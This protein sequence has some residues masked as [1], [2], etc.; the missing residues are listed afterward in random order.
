VAEGSEPVVVEVSVGAPLEVVW[1][2]LRDPEL[3]KRW[4]GW[5]YDDLDAEVDAIYVDDV[6]VDEGA[7][8]LRLGDGDRFE[9][10]A[11]DDSRT[12]VRL[13]RTPYVQGAEWSAYYA[14]I[15]EGWLSFLQQLRFMHE[16][17]GG[18]PRRT[19]FLSGT[20]GP[21]VPSQ[22]LS[23]VPVAVGEPRYVAE[24]QQGL[25]LPDLGPGLLILAVKPSTASDVEGPV[26]E[27]MAI[28]TT[29]GQDEDQ[30]ASTTRTWVDWWRSG[31]PDAEDPQV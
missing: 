20:G 7:H 28:V 4:H 9:L 12:V 10:V 31:Y 14:E 1:R 16:V 24:H 8:T 18:A 26:A 6:Q 3:I 5:H 21:A 17:Q 22:L 23:S 13:V 15:T 11:G 2:S 30:F 25:E 27:A 29:Y 19:I